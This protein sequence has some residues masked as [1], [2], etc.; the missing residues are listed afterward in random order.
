MFIQTDVSGNSLATS[1]TA[2]S[3]G[4]VGG[5]HIWGKYWGRLVQA[6]LIKTE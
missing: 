3:N 5:K 6:N 4:I 1:N 2:N